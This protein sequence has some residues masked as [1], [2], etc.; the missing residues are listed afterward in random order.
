MFLLIH[1]LNPVTGGPGGS[2][3]EVTSWRMH[4]KR[5]GDWRRR[6]KAFQG[7]KQLEQKPRGDKVRGTKETLLWLEFRTQVYVCV[8]VRVASAWVL[9]SVLGTAPG[10][11]THCLISLTLVPPGA[12]TGMMRCTLSW[13]RACAGFRGP[14]AAQFL[15]LSCEIAGPGLKELP[16]FLQKPE[17]W[18]CLWDSWLLNV[19]HYLELKTSKH[20][21]CP[22]SALG[23]Q[24][25]LS[26]WTAHAPLWGATLFPPQSPVGVVPQCHPLGSARF[27]ISNRLKEPLQMLWFNSS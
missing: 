21:L 4:G 11:W 24:L 5:P 9:W 18:L 27:G 7:R 19:G 3:R 17:I 14:T 8:C 23:W 20:G 15:S 2:L 16:A 13:S 22:I 26:V 1:S 10:V 6:R 25:A 12:G